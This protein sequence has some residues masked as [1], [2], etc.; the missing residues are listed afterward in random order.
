M[1]PARTYTETGWW[2]YALLGL[3]A[4]LMLTLASA[5]Q[6]M[7]V[8]VIVCVLALSGY[9]FG[10]ITVKIDAEA[11][12]VWL[13]PGICRCHVPLTTIRNAE[14]TR[15]GRYPRLGLIHIRGGKCYTVGER[16]ALALTLESGETIFIAIR[17]RDAI[18]RQIS[19]HAGNLA[20]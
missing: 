14:R 3:A 16:D 9:C 20:S 5:E 2:V 11:I 13:G 10:R 17:Q 19:A 15:L 4:V 18:L 7:L 6:D 8:F 12:S 1:P